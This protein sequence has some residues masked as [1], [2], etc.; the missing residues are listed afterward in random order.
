MCVLCFAASVDRY[1]LLRL[2][3]CC[4]AS[5]HQGT[6]SDL[7]RSLQHRL[8]LSLSSCMALSDQDQSGTLSLTTD[9]CRNISI[10]LRHVSEDTQLDLQDCE[11]EDSGLDLLL[12]VPERVYLR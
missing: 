8:D 6:A 12:P 9:D 11:V 3:H 10:I 7:L 4:A 1:L 5:V 2:V